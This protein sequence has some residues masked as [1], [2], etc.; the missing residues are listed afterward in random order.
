MARSN[1][2]YTRALKGNTREG[3][4]TKIRPNVAHL[5]EFG[6]PVWIF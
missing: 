3:A 4:W 1:K 6:I 2:S 5:Q